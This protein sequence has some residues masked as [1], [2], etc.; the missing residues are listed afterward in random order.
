MIKTII[1]DL[2]NTLI[3]WKDE[4]IEALIRTLKQLGFD[5]DINKIK[6]ID[7]AITKYEKYHDIYTKKSFV[8]FINDIC[9]TNLPINFADILIDEQ[10]SCYEVFSGE[11]FE[12][13][14]YLSQKYELIV[15]SNWFTKTQVERLKNAG[16]YKYFSKVTGGDEHRLKPSLKAF[17]I[18][19]NKKECVMVG[20]SIEADIE[21][22]LKLGMQAILITKKDIKKDLRYKKINK[23]EELKEIL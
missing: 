9:K 16:I 21:P 8:D 19:D 17:D 23:I 22:A 3:E 13:I 4:Y 6:E 11:E 5:Y 14:K 15:L 1:F 10:A 2:D 20:D 7:C 12:T 18:I